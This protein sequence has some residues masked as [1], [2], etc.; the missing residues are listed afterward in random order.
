MRFLRNSWYMAGWS[1]DFDPGSLCARQI[2]NEP[3]MVGRTQAGELFALAD[4][5]PHRYAPLSQGRLI[6]GESVECPY[7]GLRFDKSGRCVYNPHGAG[8]IP[9]AARVDS[10]PIAERHSIAWIWMGDLSPDEALIPD[11]SVFDEAEPASV[12]RRD[13]LVMDAN[14]KL[15]TENLLDLSHVSVLHEGILGN[16]E[17]FKAEIVVKQQGDTLFVRR[18]MLNVPVPGL[19]DMMFMRDGGRVDLWADMRWSAPGCMLN[20][21]GVTAPGASRSD[22][23]AIYGTHFL[24]PETDR[25]TRYHFAAVRINGRTWGEPIDSE[26]RSKIAELRRFAFEEQDKR[27]ID[28]QQRTIETYGSS[29]RKPVYIETDAGPL[30]FHR[31]LENLIARESRAKPDEVA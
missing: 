18:E 11:F 1:Q 7:H 29:L 24:T 5:C 31:I 15:I 28:A 25:S 19:F 27:I 14:Y 16:S 2:L 21:T 9:A 20:Y 10:Y 3:I 17:T 26:I 12:S 13:H 6:G 4:I 30:R 8:R 22:G 23:T